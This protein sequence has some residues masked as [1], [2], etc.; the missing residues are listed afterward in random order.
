MSGNSKRIY[1]TKIWRN[2]RKQAI[3]RD[4]RICQS[5]GKGLYK[6]KDPGTWPTVDHITPIGEGGEPYDIDNLQTLCR[7]CHNA[8]TLSDSLAKRKN[9]LKE[10]GPCSCIICRNTYSK[11]GL[12]KHLR[13]QH[14]IFATHEILDN[15]RYY[16]D[17]ENFIHEEFAQFPGWI[18]K[19]SKKL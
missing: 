7:I 4:R 8:K 5:C 2:L 1:D 15:P 14:D 11:K 17:N 16:T 18:E 9:D 3:K 10:M 12:A 6:G 13:N 19:W